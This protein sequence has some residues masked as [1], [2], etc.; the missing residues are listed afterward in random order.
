MKQCYS[1]ILFLLFICSF[2]TAQVTINAELRPR[3]EFR[4]GFQTLFLE[5]IDPAAFISQRTR[6][7]ADYKKEYLNFYLSVQDIRWGDVPQLNRADRNGF[8]VHQAWGE[9]RF[10][11]ELSLKLGGQVLNYNDQRI[12]GGVAWAQQARSYDVSLFKYHKNRSRFHLGAAF[13]QDGESNTGNTLTIANT[14]KS[15]QYAY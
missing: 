10:T 14:Y 9:S 12:F 3:F 7:N 1:K 8:A 4:H 15:I 6:L 5:N 13:N 2:A 11:P